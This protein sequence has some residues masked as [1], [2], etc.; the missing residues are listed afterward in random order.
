MFGTTTSE[1]QT[2]TNVRRR[3]L[4][5]AIEGANRQLADAEPLPERLTPHSLRRTFASVLFAVGEPPPY[6]MAQLG[7]TTPSLTLAIYARQMDRRDGEPERLIALVEGHKWAPIG[8]NGDLH[9]RETVDRRKP[10]PYENR[11]YSLGFHGVEP[12]Q[13]DPEPRCAR[14][15][16]IGFGRSCAN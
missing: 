2:P 10:R 8:A 3:I 9:A 6:V 13:G 5:R 16:A 1:Q 7:H 12:G 11:G 15:S 14:P 4:A